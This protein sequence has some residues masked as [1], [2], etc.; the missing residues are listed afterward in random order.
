M[1]PLNENYVNRLH[2]FQPCL[3]LICAVP[4]RFVFKDVL[5]RFLGADFHTLGLTMN[6]P[7]TVMDDIRDMPNSSLRMKID[8]FL[9]K[10]QFPSF[11]KDEETAEFLV[12]ALVKASLSDIATAVK[13][14]LEHKLHIK[15]A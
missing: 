4:I 15:G 10:Y 14:D 13:K 6:L 12:E 7:K 5:M 1:S 9:S 11:A 8:T 3:T 2:C